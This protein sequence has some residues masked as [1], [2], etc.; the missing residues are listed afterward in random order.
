MLNKPPYTKIKNNIFYFLFKIEEPDEFLDSP[1]RFIDLY[2]LEL[3]R[4]L[5]ESEINI[6]NYKIYK[7]VLELQGV[8]VPEYDYLI[9]YQE[10]LENITE[11]DLSD[12]QLT[13]LPDSIRKLIFL[14]IIS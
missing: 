10:E 4:F 9:D 6:K 3:I 11:L 7:D 12:N 8:E 5:I 2:V 14:I 13:T 1:Y